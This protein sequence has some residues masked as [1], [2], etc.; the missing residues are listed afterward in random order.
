MINNDMNDIRYKVFLHQ[1]DTTSDSAVNNVF[2][3]NMI[4]YTDVV[5]ANDIDSDLHW[6][7][8]RDN[9]DKFKNDW[10]LNTRKL[11]ADLMSLL[12][13]NSLNKLQTIEIT[14]NVKAITGYR[15]NI[16]DISNS[17]GLT[18]GMGDSD[19]VSWDPNGNALSIRDVIQENQIVELRVSRDAEDTDSAGNRH[20]Y[21]EYLGFIG[22]IQFS[23]SFGQ[24]NNIT[25]SVFGLNKLLGLSSAMNNQAIYSQ[26]EEGIEMTSP[27]VP[28]YQNNWNQLDTF[29][30]FQEVMADVLSIKPYHLDKVA[31]D[32]QNELLKQETLQDQLNAT[33]QILQNELIA[34]TGQLPADDQKRRL[35]EQAISGLQDQILRQNDVVSN[36][37][38]KSKDYFSNNRAKTAYVYF[39]TD[40]Q[41]FLRNFRTSFLTIWSYFLVRFKSLIGQ[42]FE[43]KNYPDSKTLAVVEHGEH[44]TFLE[45]I[46][47]NFT[48]FWS[49]MT[50]PIELLQSIK[51][52]SLYDVFEA[53]SGQM[54][55]R[56]PRY[57]E[58]YVGYDGAR[59][60]FPNVPGD[61]PMHNTE[62]DGDFIITKDEMLS[63][64]FIKD[65]T[66]L[67]SR[68]DTKNMF[69]LI[70]EIPIYADNFTDA[71]TLF[72]YGLRVNPPQSNP[73]VG[74]S[75]VA[76]LFSALYVYK[77]NAHTRLINVAV[78]NTRKFHVGNL[79]LL[80]F[81]DDPIEEYVGYLT[82]SEI[83]FEYDGISKTVLKFNYVRKV[84]R[85]IPDW[86]LGSDSDNR[87]EMFY[88]IYRRNLSEWCEKHNE[89][90]FNL[91]QSEQQKSVRIGVAKQFLRSIPAGTCVY[92]FKIIPT[93]L[94]VML[95]I[96]AKPS[97][98]EGDGPNKTNVQKSRLMENISNP[99]KKQ[100]GFYWYVSKE[101]TIAYM[102]FTDLTNQSNMKL[103][104]LPFGQIQNYYCSGDT[105]PIHLDVGTGV[106]FQTGIPE[107][108]FDSMSTGAY[109]FIDQAMINR[110]IEIDLSFKVYNN[111]LIK[112]IWGIFTEPPD[113]GHVYKATPHIIVP[114]TNSALSDI[115]AMFQRY[116][117]FIFQHHIIGAPDFVSQWFNIYKS[118][119]LPKS[120]EFIN[121]D[122]VLS[123]FSY[124]LPKG[125]LIY[126]NG[127][128][129]YSLSVDGGEYV[130]GVHK[131]K[132][133]A[134]TAISIDIWKNS[135]DGLSPIKFVEQDKI[136]KSNWTQVFATVFLATKAD[137]GY[138]PGQKKV[139]F[140]T[141]V[142]IALDS[143]L[144]PFRK[145]MLC[146][147]PIELG[148]EVMTTGNNLLFDIERI[149]S[150]GVIQGFRAPTDSEKTAIESAKQNP[151]IKNVSSSFDKHTVGKAV[152]FTLTNM[153]MDGGGRLHING[154]SNDPTI[155]HSYPYSSNSL[156][157]MN[158]INRLLSEMQKQYKSH[159]SYNITYLPPIIDV[160]HEWMSKDICM[161]FE[162]N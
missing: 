150:G 124:F 93:I 55:C 52:G 60:N 100:N 86:F 153:R 17:L 13:N 68:C 130:I 138:D 123:R 111:S 69:P 79:Y 162:V 146:F 95:Q 122:D 156:L 137:N 70:G 112:P 116:D 87:L 115:G 62:D 140:N 117:M 75:Y 127:I 39:S 109:S 5:D 42:D 119:T 94:D 76:S 56:P 54:I 65:D 106:M 89:D 103:E 25:V 90:D 85:H 14:D 66:T 30:I 159:S 131:D 34:M 136:A 38:Q 37:K 31:Q 44:R 3:N 4:K 142:N 77:Q 157:F 61:A 74:N 27:G 98:A 128:N 151:S 143:S 83:I 8:L 107:N 35:K 23:S 26:F 141:P 148:D 81:N 129:I 104:L 139:I 145:S 48:L 49:E 7:K 51:S 57:N 15:V 78:P 154:V 28:V 6:F 41:M 22:T 110:L 133:Y 144:C 105:A 46:T 2:Y 158:F 32:N 18:L 40:A 152:D 82:E 101:D 12:S 63:E 59:F 1:L 91:Y 99:A 84:E 160:G 126:T 10:K 113:E 29:N 134:S 155:G 72:K 9:H 149:C 114:G 108:A 71:N 47:K 19:L 67:I 161:H 73:N 53:K 43:N 97:S 96:E 36:L 125:V 92:C 20:Y 21:T 11:K 147:M 50:M 64:E 58:L 33:L 24:V 102:K 80:Q 135:N 132:N 120:A 45:Q 16:D 121:N 88:F 118:P